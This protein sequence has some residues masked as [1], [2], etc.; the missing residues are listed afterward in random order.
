MCSLS[1][2]YQKQAHSE[3]RTQAEMNYKSV[4]GKKKKKSNFCLVCGTIYLARV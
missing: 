2:A 3:L 1:L 4:H